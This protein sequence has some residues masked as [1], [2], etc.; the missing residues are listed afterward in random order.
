MAGGL[1]SRMNNPEK[2]LIEIHGEALIDRT[3]R[4]IRGICSIM[5]AAIDPSMIRL[6]EK[7]LSMDIGVI[8]RPRQGYVEDLNNAM[9]S[10]GRFP[11]LVVPGDVY[12]F[13]CSAFLDS[14]RR[15]MSTQADVVSL[16][17]GGKYTGVSIFNAPSGSY[18]NIDLLGSAANINTLEDLRYVIERDRT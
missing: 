13:K 6:R 15:A 18:K 8:M 7:L 11:I 9:I 10:I 14:L 5:Y 1:G 2:A 4:C 12:I 17:D 3:V 16:T